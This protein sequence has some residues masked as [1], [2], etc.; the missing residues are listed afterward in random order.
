MTRSDELDDHIARTYGVEV[1]QLTQLDA[2]VFRIDRHDGPSWV[3][4]VFPEA[5]PVEGTQGDAAI[6][7]ALERSGFP[8]ERCAAPEPVSIFGRESV[9]VTE[10]VRAGAPLRPGRT[11]AIL[12][13]L[14]GRLHSHPADGSRA[15]GAW[16]H[17]SFTGAPRDEVAAARE[18]LEQAQSRIG[19]RELGRYHALCDAVEQTDDCADLPH[20]FVHPDFVA[21][22]A[23][24][25]AEEMLVIV[26]WA[27][28]GR[29]PRLWS[30]GFLLWAAAVHSPKLVDVA[31]TR[32]RRHITLES[33]ELERLA[34]AIRARPVML[35]CWS[36]CAGRRQLDDALARIETANQLAPRIA[37]QARRALASPD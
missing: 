12:G 19:L 10:F 34:D 9:L 6:L 24:P 1:S 20:A 33:A 4:R 14:L 32:Y 13:A 18:L 8:A 29:G 27:G 28:S 17:L 23:I 31:V 7:R 22:N 37:E 35:E 2:G 30:L 36:F 15:G 21:A 25:T 3:A 16:H 5:R 26:D 11:A